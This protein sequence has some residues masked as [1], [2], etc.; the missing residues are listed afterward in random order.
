MKGE[1]LSP[2]E[3]LRQARDFTQTLRKGRRAESGLFTLVLLRQTHPGAARLG[4]AVS[5]RVGGSVQRNLAKRLIREAFRRHKGRGYD[6]VVLPKAGLVQA[7]LSDVQQQLAQL[8]GRLLKDR[9][10][11]RGLRPDPAD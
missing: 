10:G 4:L 2:R 11:S 7:R 3:R 6:L 5:R 8:L 9:G 1:G